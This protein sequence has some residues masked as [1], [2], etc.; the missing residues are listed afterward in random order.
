MKNEQFFTRQNV[1][2]QLLALTFTLAVKQSVLINK[3][4]DDIL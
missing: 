3:R 2:K 4:K 1:S